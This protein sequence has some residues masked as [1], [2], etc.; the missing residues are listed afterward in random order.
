VERHE[1]SAVLTGA[2]DR[3]PAAGEGQ[4]RAV[5]NADPLTI[6]EQPGISG[7]L[8]RPTRRRAP[9]GRPCSLKATCPATLV[10]RWRLSHRHKGY[11][12]V[13]SFS[14]RDVEVG[15][16][17]VGHVQALEY[18]GLASVGLERRSISSVG[19]MVH[20]IEVRADP[21]EVDDI[22]PRLEIGDRVA[23]NTFRRRVEH[24]GVIPD[25]AGQRVVARVA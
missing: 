16:V 25:S 14:S 6:Y 1:Q 18:N 12:A 11:E 2:R 4:V 9:M 15:G 24:E 22:L 19:E 5:S 13:V 20:H 3:Q 21:V 17:K 23:L 7:G 8:A 10:W